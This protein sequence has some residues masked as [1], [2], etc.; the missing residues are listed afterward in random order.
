MCISSN[1]GLEE[2]SYLVLSEAGDVRPSGSLL[3]SRPELVHEKLGD[4]VVEVARE[5]ALDQTHDL[6][7]FRLGKTPAKI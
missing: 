6:L 3:E 7:A 1:G 2:G 4:R 5:N